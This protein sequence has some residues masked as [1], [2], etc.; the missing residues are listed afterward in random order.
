MADIYSVSQL[1]FVPSFIGHFGHVV[2]ECMGCTTP[3]GQTRAVSRTSCC[4]LSMSWLPAAEDHRPQHGPFGSRPVD[5]TLYEAIMR[6]PKE[7]W[8]TT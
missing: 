6:P 7:D 8:K 4:Q 5:N 2:V 1:G 3:A